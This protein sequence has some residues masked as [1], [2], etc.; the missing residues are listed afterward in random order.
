MI[1]QALYRY[2]T[3]L[4]ENEGNDLPGADYSSV[5]VSFEMQLDEAGRLVA[6]LPYTDDKGKIDKRSFLVPRQEKRAY[7]IKPYFLCEKVEY[8]FG[9]ALAQIDPCR[10]ALGLDEETPAKQKKK[11][12]R[13]ADERNAMKELWLQVLALTGL[14]L[15]E[16]RALQAFLSA[17]PGEL[18][19]QVRLAVDEQIQKQVCGSGLGVLKYAPTG[20][21]VHELQPIKAI[22]EGFCA[23]GGEGSSVQDGQICLITGEVTPEGDIAR[24]HPDIKNVYGARSSGAALVSFNIE[25]FCSY[26]RTQSYNAPTSQKAADAYGYVL[27][28]LLSDPRHKVRLN[29]TTVVFWAESAGPREQDWLASL[30]ADFEQTDHPDE[31]SVRARVRSAVVRV[32]RG[33]QFTDTFGD[34]DPSTTFYV[35]GLSPNASRLSV[36]FWYSGSLS[37]LGER[38]WRHFQDLSIAGLERTP[39][40]RELLRELAFDHDW[41]KIPHNMEGQML[42]SILL[43]LP[44]SK[45]VFSQLMNRVRADS[46]KP[47][48]GLRKIGATRAALIKAYL[49]RY[50]R[51]TQN[52]MEGEITMGLNEDAKSVPYHLGRLFACLEKAQAGALGTEVNA[53]IRDRFWGAASTS[54]ATVFPRLLHL[55]QHH[56]SKDEKWGGFHDHKIEEVMNSLPSQLPRRLSLEEQGMF[57][58]GYYH[59]RHDFYA[60]KSDE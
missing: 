12:Q 35:L 29:D 49:L 47:E 3:L 58:L 7:G 56:V 38:V 9:S 27:N 53:T 25:S 41:N 44:Y 22:W 40:I 54:P 50:Y 14:E 51:R 18:A 4:Q 6:L 11:V 1:L 59:Q 43:G 20:R 24:L 10:A 33:Q 19:D 2:R 21:Y 55:A 31:E 42:R 46:D 17:S 16:V 60:K 15:P 39:T 23:A 26:G 5:R 34:L 48:K 28:R 13:L 37:Q 57:A 52:A 8:L 45:A 30:F 32:Q 36:R